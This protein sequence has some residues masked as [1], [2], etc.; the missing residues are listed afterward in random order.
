MEVHR[1]VL[2]C[3]ILLVVMYG[4]EAWTIS[5]EIENQSGATEMWFLSR[6]LR[7]SYVDKARNE[8]A[9]EKAGTM[10][11]LVKEAR[12]RKQHSLDM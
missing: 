12:K 7:I 3:Y 4:C 11:S 8:E 5:K 1:I 10:R 9:L 6:M 2:D